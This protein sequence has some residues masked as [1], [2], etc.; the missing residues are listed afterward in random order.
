[1]TEVCGHCRRVVDQF[2]GI[3]DEFIW[4]HTQCYYLIT[5]KRVDKLQKKCK[6]GTI[7]LSE[8][9]ELSELLVIISNV[10]KTLHEPTITMSEILDRKN[11][12]IFGESVG[13]QKLSQDIIK[14]K[15]HKELEASRADEPIKLP[16]TKNKVFG[17]IG[18]EKHQ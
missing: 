18:N 7:T 10:K 2:E 17:I 4:Y 15:K 8:A 5:K 9:E 16:P 3:V 12:R 11:P 1:M 13:L 14:L 6:G